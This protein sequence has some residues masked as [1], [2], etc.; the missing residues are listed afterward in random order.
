MEKKEKTKNFVFQYRKD[1]IT[2]AYN[3]LS[4]SQSNT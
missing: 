1:S 3:S 2:E 4:Q